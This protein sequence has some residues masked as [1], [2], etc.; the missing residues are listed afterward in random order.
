VVRHKTIPYDELGTG[1]VFGKPG[2]L[3][4]PVVKLCHFGPP[5]PLWIYIPNT[6][7]NSSTEIRRQ[8]CSTRVPGNPTQVGSLRFYGECRGT[9]RLPNRRQYED[10]MKNEHKIARGC[11]GRHSRRRPAKQLSGRAQRQPIYV[12]RYVDDPYDLRRTDGSIAQAY[13]GLAPEAV[14]RRYEQFDVNS[15]SISEAASTHVR[16]PRQR[17]V[18]PLGSLRG[19]LPLPM[20]PLWLWHCP[21][22]H[23]D[24][25]EVVR[26]AGSRR[27]PPGQE[28][29]QRFIK[30]D[31]MWC[32]HPDRR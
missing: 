4:R 29:W 3:N 23:E 16:P 6:G 32:F 15:R 24:R 9:P 27:E 20:V 11:R 28:R 18:R 2:Y 10:L 8:P 31:T 22:S 14:S 1:E 13:H 25:P 21:A 26:D 19:S 17:P 7:A 12:G 30:F 5:D